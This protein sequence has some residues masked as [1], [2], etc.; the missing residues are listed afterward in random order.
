MT[1]LAACDSKLAERKAD[2]RLRAAIV[3]VICAKDKSDMQIAIG[4][5]TVAAGDISEPY[6]EDTAWNLYEE[7]DDKPCPTTAAGGV[8]PKDRAAA[9]SS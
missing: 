6:R 3:D 8:L 5:L 1:L 4:S 9:G 7:V 2:D